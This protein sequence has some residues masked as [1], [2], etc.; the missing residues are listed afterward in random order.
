MFV[1]LF[2]TLFYYVTY[3]LNW[4]I[5]EMPI[6]VVYNMAP[7]TS[8]TSYDYKPVDIV[9]VIASFD[10]LGHI[11]PLWV[12]IGSSAYKVE[13]CW[14]TSGQYSR[15]VSFNCRLKDRDCLR[16]LTLSYHQV[17]GMWT[18]DRSFIN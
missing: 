11:K 8:Y 5:P 2:Q 15:I 9:S 17:E 12:R 10:T 14:R 6:P 18:M 1:Y 4:H 16:P 3:F 7:R 13:S